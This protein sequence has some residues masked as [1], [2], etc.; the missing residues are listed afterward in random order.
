MNSLTAYFTFDGHCREAMMFYQSCLG[1][2]LYFQKVGDTPEAEKLPSQMKDC[3]LHA[4]LKKDDMIIMGTDMV[5]DEGLKHGNSISVLLFCRD[6]N[7]LR[8]IYRKL[9]VYGKATI[10]VSARGSGG[11]FAG[12][13][14]KYGIHWL[15]R[16]EIVPQ[17]S[18]IYLPQILTIQ[19]N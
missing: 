17:E 1:G 11:L 14:D 10:P 5:S 13:T 9:V 2:E 7:C 19:K 8:K 18:K 16:C 12:L 3:I 4:T 6:S 15:L